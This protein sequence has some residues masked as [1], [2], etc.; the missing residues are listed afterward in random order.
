MIVG[1]CLRS[2]SYC[3]V[4]SVFLLKEAASVQLIFIQAEHRELFSVSAVA[5]KLAFL[6]TDAFSPS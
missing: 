2:I 1:H 6:K 5:L 3:S 4:I